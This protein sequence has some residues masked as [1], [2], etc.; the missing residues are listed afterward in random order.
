MSEVIYWWIPNVLT[1]VGLGVCI[2]QGVRTRNLGL[3]LFALYFAFNLVTSVIGAVRQH[4]REAEYLRSFVRQQIGPNAWTAPVLHHS[5]NLAAPFTSA[6]L[7][8]VAI[9]F[10]RSLAAR[11]AA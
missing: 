6:L 3:G 10:A 2:V 9:L 4:Q 1:A 5:Y 8:L 11:R 7:V